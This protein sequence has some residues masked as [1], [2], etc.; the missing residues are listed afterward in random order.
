VEGKQLLYIKRVALI[1]AVISLMALLNGCIRGGNTQNDSYRQY[2]STTVKKLGVVMGLPNRFDVASSQVVISSLNKAA[3]DL[4]AEIKILQPGDLVNNEE[5]LRYMAENNFNLVVAVGKEME[6]ALEKVAPEYEDIRFILVEGN[7][8]QP[9]VASIGYRDNDAVF[10]AGVTA[11]YLTKSNL[12]GFVGDPMQI[13]RLGEMDFA[14]GVQFAIASEE[15]NIKVVT[16]YGNLTDKPAVMAEQGKSLANS[17]YWKGCDVIYCNGINYSSGAAAAAIENRK[18]ALCDDVQLMK[19]SPRNV[20]GAISRNKEKVVYDLVIKSF[21]SGFKGGKTEFG[22][23]NGAVDFVLSPSLQSDIG[24]KVAAAK[25][26]LKNG[27]IITK[28]IKIPPDSLIKIS[29]L[30]TQVPVKKTQSAPKK[31]SDVQ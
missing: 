24:I 6:I 30:I 23:V 17:L 2:G 7:V 8:D 29:Q 10:L 4:D 28:N 3:E 19:T 14:R 9:N 18:I 16:A 1:M 22:L 15:K 25:N 20:V 31:T 21:V 27:R 12:V 13:D 26:L 5:S 11:A